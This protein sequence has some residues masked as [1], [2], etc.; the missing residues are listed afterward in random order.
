MEVCHD[1]PAYEEEILHGVEV[2]TDLPPRLYHDLQVILRRLVAKA[3][4]LLEK[5]TTNLAES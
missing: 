4:Q 3:E 2:A 1:N 5:V